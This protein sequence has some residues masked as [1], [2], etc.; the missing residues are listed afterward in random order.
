MDLGGW[1]R[2]LGLDNYQPAF[3]EY[4][5]DNTVLPSLM[6]LCLKGDSRSLGRQ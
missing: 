3:R 2:S 6:L 1:L 5:I 4:A